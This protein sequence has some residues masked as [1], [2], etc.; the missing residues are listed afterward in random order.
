MKSLNTKENHIA[1][2]LIR[3]FDGSSRGKLLQANSFSLLQVFKYMQAPCSSDMLHV[4]EHKTSTTSLPS[5]ILPVCNTFILLKYSIF[6]GNGTFCV[7][8][9]WDFHSTQT[10][11]FLRSV[12]PKRTKFKC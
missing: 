8:N 5:C 7:R 2:P 6:F 11:L 4:L 12:D 1:F 9:Q 10:T 3:V